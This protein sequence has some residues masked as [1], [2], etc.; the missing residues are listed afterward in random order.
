MPNWDFFF[1]RKYNFNFDS[2]RLNGIIILKNSK[3]LILWGKKSSEISR[4]RC[5]NFSPG[6]FYEKVNNRWEWT[7]RICCSGDQK[8][9]TWSQVS[10]S[11]LCKNLEGQGISHDLQ[12][13]AHG[14]PWTTAPPGAP[15]WLWGRHNVTKS[16]SD[17][18]TYFRK[19]H[20]NVEKGKKEEERESYLT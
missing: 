13:G 11:T 7:I 5:Q 1:V 10:S 19:L 20:E 18:Q 9:M 8:A 17:R 3:I 14:A 15:A 2:F 12:D 16:S 4:C 6:Y